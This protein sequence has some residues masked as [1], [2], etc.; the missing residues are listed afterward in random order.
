MHLRYWIERK[1]NF[2]LPDS[3]VDDTVLLRNTC[4]LHV[5]YYLT[6]KRGYYPGVVFL[7]LPTSRMC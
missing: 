4:L 6:D 5:K 2:Q 7:P 3:G 1:K